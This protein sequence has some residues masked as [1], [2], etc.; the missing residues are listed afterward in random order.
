LICR[1]IFIS[2]PG[3]IGQNSKGKEEEVMS[4]KNAARSGQNFIRVMLHSGTRSNPMGD[5]ELAIF[6]RCNTEQ[7]SAGDVDL[8]QLLYWV[9]NNPACKKNQSNEHYRLSRQ[10][11]A[12]SVIF[13]NDKEIQSCSNANRIFPS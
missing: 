13:L 5:E 9:N 8:R 10:A 4:Q 7:P 1:R 12:M 3:P 2:L 11:D 6:C